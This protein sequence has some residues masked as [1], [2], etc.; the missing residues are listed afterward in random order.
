MFIV[1]IIM[2]VGI[3]LSTLFG[4]NIKTDV[5]VN[6]KYNNVEYLRDLDDTLLN[7]EYNATIEY[8]PKLV[9]RNIKHE[10]KIIFKRDQLLLTPTEKVNYKI[11][12]SKP[13]SVKKFRKMELIYKNSDSL[14]TS[15]NFANY[16]VTFVKNKIEKKI[17]FVNDY[18]DR[19]LNLNLDLDLTKMNYEEKSKVYLIK[20]MLGLD[21]NDVWQTTKLDSSSLIQKRFLKKIT[22]KDIIEIYTKKEVKIQSIVFGINQKSSKKVEETFLV[23]AEYTDQRTDDKYNIYRFDMSNYLKNYFPNKD[24]IYLTELQI[25]LTKFNIGDVQKIQFLHTKIDKKNNENYKVIKM[26]NIINKHEINFNNHTDIILEDIKSSISSN[27][28][29]RI[30]TILDKY[31]PVE[32]QTFTLQDIK[33]ILLDR[34]IYGNDNNFTIMDA[35]VR[36]AESGNI[37]DVEDEKVMYFSNKQLTMKD[38]LDKDVLFEFSNKKYYANE[39]KNVLNTNKITMNVNVKNKLPIFTI[40]SSRYF[41]IDSVTL[42]PNFSISKEQLLKIDKAKENNKENVKNESKKEDGFSITI[43]PI[44]ESLAR[45][46]AIAVLFYFSLFLRPWILRKFKSIGQIIYQS[47]GSIFFSWA[48]LLWI[49]TGIFVSMK[50]EP[51]AVQISA[52]AFYLL[53]WGTVKEII[54]LRKSKVE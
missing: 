4:N 45:I 2:S 13:L 53:I 33:K 5:L 26:S 3:L 14:S 17:K 25:F 49:L 27:A 36:D 37:L 50:L 9:Q 51:I 10:E 46:F 24:F 41:N 18:R 19:D 28:I 29:I 34:K 31:F 7:G 23:Q 38:I 54:A 35:L 6:Y 15:Q 20:R 12:F 8:S 42:I 22:S 44:Y 1:R 48:I 21:F 40:D 39:V 52:L 30:P 11:N 47:N 16:N 43:L 32:T